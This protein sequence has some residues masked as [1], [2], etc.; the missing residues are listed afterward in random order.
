MAFSRYSGGVV[1]ESS[2]GLDFGERESEQR[3]ELGVWLGERSVASARVWSAGNGNDKMIIMR[4][5]NG[6]IIKAVNWF[7]PQ[8]FPSIQIQ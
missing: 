1:I 8:A 2:N 6:K 4:S 3:I 7:V 5:F